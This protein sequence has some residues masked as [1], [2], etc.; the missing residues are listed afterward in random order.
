MNSCMGGVRPAW[1][2]GGDMGCWLACLLVELLVEGTICILAFYSIGYT[3]SGQIIMDP[4]CIIIGHSVNILYNK[5]LMCKL[6][7]RPGVQPAGRLAN[8]PCL[9][10]LARAGW[11][12]PMH[13]FMHRASNIYKH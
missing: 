7:P 13:K 8:R 4:Q 11:T 3:L 12:P 2:G 10:P 5:R 9:L 6:S 1:P